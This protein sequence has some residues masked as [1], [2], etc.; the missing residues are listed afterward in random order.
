MNDWFEKARYGLVVHFGL[1]SMLGRGE[2]VMNKEDISPAE[3]RKMAERFNPHLFDAE[4]IADLAV[5]GGMKYVVFTTMHH[6]GYRMYHSDL[7]DFCS[8]K[9]GPK[10]DFVAEIIAAARKRGLRIGLYHSLNN[11]F[12]QPDAVA[13]LE[14]KAA[15]QVFIENTLARIKELNAKYKPFD[16]MWYDGWWPFDAKG[17]QAE[18]MNEM[19]RKIQPDI[20]FNGRNCLPGDFATPEQHIT[21]PTPWRPWEA[22]I[23]L[24]DSWGFHAGDHNWKPPMEVIK[25]LAKVA[26]GKGNLL[27]NIGPK[28]DGSVPV[29]SERII[30]AV[31]DWLKVNGEA[32]FDTEVWTF[33]LQ[34][35]DESHRADWSHHGPFTVKGNQLYLI[36]TS[37]P[38]ERLI[39]TGLEGTVR[40]VRRLGGDV[41]PH[42]QKEGRV[43]V[44]VGHAPPADQL[45]VVFRLT[46]D[47]PPVIYRTGGLRVPAVPHPRYDPITSDIV[48]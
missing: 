34:R 15:Y 13:A 27:L 41:L 33:D 20:L 11:W 16:I 10:R 39:I 12:D 14:D 9:I 31:G 4:H 32:L 2:W 6:E 23:T 45:P 3:L 47:R 46:C 18:R 5:A 35:K 24:N 19:V 38:N 1:Y 44:T 8:T 37:F 36:A 26:Q 25:M 17:W 28:G 42:T 21:P 22:C 43:E 40:E 48:L 29:Q 30:R 7:T